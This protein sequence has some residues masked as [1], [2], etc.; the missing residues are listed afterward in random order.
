MSAAVSAAGR[1]PG[2]R[3]RRRI[4]GLLAALSTAAALAAGPGAAPAAAATATL[5]STTAG[6]STDS[7]DSHYLNASRYV[8]GAAGGTVSSISVYVGAV[9]AAPADQFQAAVYRDNGGS[10]GALLATSAS[11]RLTANSWNTVPLT[12][13]LS[14]NTPY[15]LAYNSNGGGPAVNNLHYSPGGTSVYGNGGRTFGSWPADFGATTTSGLSFSIYATYTTEDAPPPPPP[16]SG[17]GS[18]GP[19]LLVTSQANPYTRYLAEI[20]KAE[21]LNAYRTVD[22][23]AVTATLLASYDVVLLGEMPLTAAQAATFTS[24]TNGG[25]RLVAMRP[26]KQLAPLFGLTPA[27]GTRADAYLK[28]D[29]GAAP[30]AGITGDTMGYHGPADLYT[31]SGATAVATLYSD[32]GTATANPAV[33]LR[34]AG[35]GRAAA[36]SYDL[37][38]SVV[39][40]RQGNAAWAGQQRDGTDGYEAGEMFFGTGGQPDWNNL[41][42]A[43][44]PVADEQQRLLANLI[45]L[46]DAANKPLPR[47]WY[48]PRDVKAVVVMTGDDHGVGGTA[49]RWDGYIAQSPPGCNVANWECVRGSSYIYTDDPLTPAQA[50]AY[51]DQGFEVGVHVTTN[52]RPWGTT[53]ALQGYYRDQLANWRAK[54]PSL[55]GP[56]SS[57]THCVE[58]DDWATQARTKLA[59]GIRLDTD[60]YFYPSNFTKD[61]PGYFNGTAQ[62]MRFADT[63]GSVI[64]EYQATTQLTDESGQSYPGTISTLL[65]AAY[66][67]QGYYAALTANIHTDFAASSASDAIIAAA[68]AR[69]VPVVSGRQMLTWLDARNGSAFTKLAWSG[70][71]LG[72]DITG[73]ANGLRAMLPV[74]AASGTLT[75]I[76]SGGRAVPYRIET[77]KGVSYAFFDGAVGSYTASYGRDTTP[78]AVIGTSP[79]AGATGVAAGS[80]VRFSFGEPLDQASVTA[81]T[82]TLR[83]AGGAAVAGTVAYDGAANGVVLTPTAPLALSTGYTATVQGVRDTSGNVQAGPVTVS[84]TTGGAPPRTLGNTVVGASVDDTDSHHLNGSRITTGASAAPLTALSV[85]VGPVSAAPDNQ[86]QLAVYT[87][88]GG[89]PGTLVASTGSGTLTANAWNVL[90]VNVTLSA[91]TAYWLVYNSNGTGATVNNMNYSTGPAGSGAYSNAVVPFGTWPATFGPAVKDTLLYSLYGS[92]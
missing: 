54:Y 42:K 23:S 4:A 6:P 69:G 41:D 62:I 49:G 88:A 47:F 87:D 83:T 55:P 26:D 70:S 82:A 2:V 76:T 34:T 36:F 90:P 27:T 18:E 28:V 75:G 37:A 19:V 66:G 39:Q 74:S 9:D 59:N 1:R 60:Y 52:C 8:T 11:A 85:H 71:S 29:T 5:G 63:D 21:G 38:R 44:I 33:T 30:G 61:R 16:G 86:F 92:Y 22:I 89:S 45:T 15:W 81:A 65:D 10:P 56:S 53:A 32:A 17:P 73:G 46:V 79:A 64:D 50:Q 77:V 91:N 78:P 84:F 7:G 72:F 68:R 3:W 20:L 35:S 25:G 13:A 12:A 40:T 48:F 14:A 43:L 80:A 58:W 51:T 31:L 57:R 24:W 67:A